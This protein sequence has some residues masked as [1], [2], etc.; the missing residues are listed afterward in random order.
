MKMKEIK[1]CFVGSSIIALK[2]I[3]THFYTGISVVYFQLG[4]CLLGVLVLSREF[5]GT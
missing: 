3:V 4:C 1:Q 5:L 2:K